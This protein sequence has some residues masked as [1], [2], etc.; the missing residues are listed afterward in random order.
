LASVAIT[1]RRT[2]A[3]VV[4]FHLS[5]PLLVTF[6]VYAY[7]DVWPLLTFTLVLADGW[8]VT[9]LWA[10]IDLRSVLGILIPLISPRQYVPLDPKARFSFLSRHRVCSWHPL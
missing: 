7:R 6:S 2:R 5:A 10:K 4:L 9:L 8:E 3:S 1:A